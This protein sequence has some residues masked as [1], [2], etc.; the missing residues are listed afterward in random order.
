MSNFFKIGLFSL[1]F[2]GC[3]KKED[4]LFEKLAPNKSNITFK[5]QLLPS[6]NPIIIKVQ[7]AKEI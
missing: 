1:L 6:K 3:A 4:L 7:L 2:F 5:N